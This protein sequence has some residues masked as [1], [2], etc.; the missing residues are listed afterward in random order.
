MT[1][2]CPNRKAQTLSS[3]PAFPCAHHGPFPR[4]LLCFLPV[5]C[6]H[7]DFIV[8]CPPVNKLFV[9]QAHFDSFLFISPS[10]L[11][12]NATPSEKAL[13]SFLQ[14]YW[15]RYGLLPSAPFLYG[16]G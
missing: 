15:I 14:P 9:S 1:F 2:H 10:M 4:C 7:T 3:A 12:L 5:L 16:F 13:P 8:T 6:S 11:L